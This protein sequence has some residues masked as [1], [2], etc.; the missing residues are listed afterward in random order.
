MLAVVG[1]TAGPNGR[2]FV[3]GIDFFPSKFKKKIHGQRHHN[4]IQ[5]MA[6]QSDKAEA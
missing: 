4:L 6:F 5:I 2:K 1:Q 3:E